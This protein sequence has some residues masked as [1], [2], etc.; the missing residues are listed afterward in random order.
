MEKKPI[1][2]I[3]PEWLKDYTVVA[4]LGVIFILLFF[5]F[6]STFNLP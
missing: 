5:W 4:I 6:T 1:D 2:D 3:K